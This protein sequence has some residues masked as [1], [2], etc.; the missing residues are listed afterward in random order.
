MFYL[1]KNYSIYPASIQA[2]FF[3]AS[4]LYLVNN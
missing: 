1:A 3:S 2:K 4:N